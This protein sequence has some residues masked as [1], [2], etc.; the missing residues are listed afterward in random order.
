MY[1]RFEDDDRIFFV[2]DFFLCVIGF[3]RS[4]AFVD[5]RCIK[6]RWE[7]VNERCGRCS[8]TKQVCCLFLVG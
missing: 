8:I 1:M 4:I 7:D 2:V 3:V 6:I 5:T